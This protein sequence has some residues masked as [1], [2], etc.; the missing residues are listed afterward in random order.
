VRELANP[1]GLPFLPGVGMNSTLQNPLQPGQSAADDVYQ[2][3]KTWFFVEEEVLPGIDRDGKPTPAHLSSFAR[4]LG[5]YVNV[6]TNTYIQGISG[7]YEMMMVAEQL[8][9]SPQLTDTDPD[10]GKS[11]Q[12]VAAE[13][14]DYMLQT[15]KEMLGQWAD[16]YTAQF[17]W[18]DSQYNSFFGFPQVRFSAEQRPPFPLR[19]LSARGGRDRALRP[20]G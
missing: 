16:V 6:Q 17:F 5:T 9:H 3:M 1:G 8:S 12:L 11:K 15:L 18:Y 7:V 2:T 19:L 20:A 14:R 10:F 4:N 13:M